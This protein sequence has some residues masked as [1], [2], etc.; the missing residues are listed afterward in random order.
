MEQGTSIVRMRKEQIKLAPK[1]IVKD[2]F[3][4][5]ETVA[6]CDQSFF[7][8][9][10]LSVIVICDAKTMEVKEK[11]Y[12]VV[13]VMIPYMPEYRSFREMPAIIDA[14]HKLERDFDL[15]LVP[16]QGILHPRKMGIASHLGLVLDKPTIGVGSN[17]LCGEEKDGKIY[18]DGNLAGMLVK[19]RDYANPLY[20]SP[21]HRISVQTS[22]QMIKEMVREPHKL[23]E[24]MNIAH[25]Y[26][27][28]IRE[29]L[30]SQTEKPKR[31]HEEEHKESNTDN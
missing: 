3:D 15:L 27:K 19:T 18:L 31:V 24:P 10:I 17:P 9:K 13:P 30:M 29:K 14:Y 1:I 26:S 4:K 25:K 11:K 28:K 22:A 16:G 20:V 7:D 21:G 8:T 2:M 12:S 23:P 6:A 5:I